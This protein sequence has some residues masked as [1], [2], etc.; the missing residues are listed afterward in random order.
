MQ[1]PA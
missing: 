1:R